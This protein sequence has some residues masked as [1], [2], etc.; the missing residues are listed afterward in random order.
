MIRLKRLT[1]CCRAVTNVEFALVAPVLF[2]LTFGVIEVG[3]VMFSTAL[4]ERATSSA[5]RIGFTSSSHII[6]IDRPLEDQVLA[7]IRQSVSGFL[8]PDSLTIDIVPADG[9]LEE[10][11]DCD[12]GA[13]HCFRVDFGRASQLV[14]YRVSYPWQVK[15]PVASAF[16]DEGVVTLTGNVAIVNEADFDETRSLF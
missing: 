10:P 13:V 11:L 14:Q 6:D 16:F 3:L 5:S 15:T 7:H 8:N 12:P 9:T 2:L 1:Q 4:L